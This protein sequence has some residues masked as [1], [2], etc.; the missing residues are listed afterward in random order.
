YNRVVLYRVGPGP[1]LGIVRDI[2]LAGRPVDVRSARDSIYV[3]ER[4]ANDARHLEEAFWERF[5]F[6]GQPVGEKFRLGFDPDDMALADDHRTP[7]LLLSG[8][9]EGDPHRPKPSLRVFNLEDS[10]HPML[11]GEVFFDAPGDD[12]YRLAFSD[13]TRRAVVSLVG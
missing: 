2:P 13:A 9:A 3:L 7:L 1:A 11:K 8:N 5:D 10:A 4:P 12:P 6:R